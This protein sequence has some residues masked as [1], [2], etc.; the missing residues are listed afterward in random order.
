MGRSIV[1]NMLAAGHPVKAIAPTKEDLNNVESKITKALNHCREM[2][3]LSLPLNDALSNLT[4]S[5]DYEI[6][7]D[8]QLVIECVIEQIPIKQTVLNKIDRAIAPDAIIGTNTSAIPISLL[9]QLVSNPQRFL[10]IHWAEPAYLTRFLEVICGDKS[11]IASA[12]WVSDLA[13]CWR[14]EATILKKDIPGFITNRL[15]YAVFREMFALVEGGH[16][17][18]EDI[19]KSFRYDVGSWVTLMGVFRRWDYIGLEDLEGMN[20]LFKKLSNSELVP[21]T[22]S[23]L[24]DS[25]ARGL[26]NGRGLFNY[27]EEEAQKWSDAFESFNN[28]IYDLAAEY[29]AVQ[30]VHLPKP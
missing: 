7:S 28:E 27:T 26:L 13:V 16:I 3:I 18:L 19:D 20:K 4:I 8:C 29:P 21:E 25:G 22:M 30:P 17:S 10:G 12:Q 23:R 14:K 2:D 9:Q 11:D 15:M 24:V 6:L 1:V 5:E